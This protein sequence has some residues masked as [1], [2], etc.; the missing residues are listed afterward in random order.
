MYAW[1]SAQG[2][3][4]NPFILGNFRPFWEN[5]LDIMNIIIPSHTPPALI[6]CDVSVSRSISCFS[7]SNTATAPLAEKLHHT[8]SS[9]KRT[10]AP[11]QFSAKQPLFNKLKQVHL[12]ECND[13]RICLAGDYQTKRRILRYIHQLF[14]IAI[15]F[16]CFYLFLIT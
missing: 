2:N 12:A 7:H 10:K 11:Q 3:E 9:N 1:K 13:I 5:V 16:E 15:I 14:K 6:F 4:R 8:L